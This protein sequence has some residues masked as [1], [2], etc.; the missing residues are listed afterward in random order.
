MVGSD[1]SAVKQRSVWGGLFY[2]GM[3]ALVWLGLGL[4]G[5]AFVYALDLP[6]TDDLWRVERSPE[7]HIYSAQDTLLDR[8]GNAGQSRDGLLFADLPP[9]LVEAVVSIEDR[10]FF[11]HFGLDPRG[12][13]RAMLVNLRAG[14][15]EQGGS[16]LTQQLAKNVFLTPE[17]T[18]KR[19]VQELL[20]AFW[21]EAKLTKQEIIALYLNRVYFGAGAYGVQA[22][23]DIYFNRPAQS[24]TL[25]EAAILAGLLKAPSRYAPTRDPQ[26]A[27]ARATLVLQAMREAG[28]LDNQPDTE[29]LLASVV[30]QP[31][32]NNAAHYALDWA[33]EQLP[34][35]VGRPGADLDVMTTIDPTMQ[36]A[37]EQII[38]RQLETQGRR[39]GATQAA[40]VVMTPDGAVRAMVGGRAYARSQFNRAVSAQR[41][42]GSAFKP[43]VY[44]AAL[45]NG[46]KPDDRFIDAPFSVGDWTPKNY[47]DEYRGNVT[48]Q[49]ALIYSLNTVATQISE[50]TGRD[51]VIAIAERLGISSPLKPHPSLALGSF[52]V[53]LLE[54]TSAYAHF[55]NGGFQTIPYVISNVVTATGDVLYERQLAKPLRVVAKDDV[56][57]M[58]AMLH[59]A[60]VNGT[61]RR[62]AING[63]QIGGKTGTSQ[64]WRD[65]W[66]VGYTGALVVGVWVGNDDGRAMQ[67]VTGGG[68]PA[69]IWHD[70]MTRQK[71]RARADL[72]GMGS[73]ESDFLK[74]L[75]GG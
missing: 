66:F 29:N 24:L 71:D 49:Q 75:F 31:R 37:A 11:D 22:A 12:L 16:T 56:A 13:A 7:I 4:G 42:P 40:M 58:N 64:N 2:W 74:W 23:A 60:T 33:M 73:Q 59:A 65:A 1:D 44:L 45:E 48:A 41:Q 34:D 25:G 50:A 68:L 17:R 53:N 47:N 8:R 28:Y 21:L 69:Q 35:F 46:L 30:I 6:D 61:G 51:K 63:L 19:K 52:E 70:F 32:S 3:V 26:A 10:R 39:L 38:Q 14:R 27:R 67:R 62:A 54:L 5:L 43:L 72:P 20:L 57:A 55:A 9:H 36:L 18:F 15:L